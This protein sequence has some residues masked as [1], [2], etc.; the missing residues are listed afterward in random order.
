MEINAK[1]INELAKE[2]GFIRDNLE[3]MAR[4]LQMLDVLFASPWK[5][6]LVLKGGT[7]INLF[8]AGLPRLSVDIDLDYC[9]ASKEETVKDKAAIADFVS[10][11]LLPLGYRLSDAGKT[12]YALDSF[13]LQ[14]VNTAGNQ[15]NVKIE[16][17]SSV[18]CEV[19]LS[20]GERMPYKSGDVMTADGTYRFYITDVAGN[21]F[22]TMVKKDT[23]VEFAFINGYN[24]RPVENGGVI[25]Q[26]SARFVT[27]NKDSSKID[28]IVLNGVEYDPSQAIGFGETGKWEFLISDD[29]GNKT[30]FYFYVVTH[31][32]SRFEYVSPYTYKITNVQY[33]AGDG[34]LIS[35]M[36]NVT[37]YA[38]NSKIRKRF[39]S[40]HGIFYG[41]VGA[42]LV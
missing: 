30:Y 6:K 19:S 12:Y 22:T 3:K 42:I 2:T 15:D 11:A 34:V 23:L 8:Y 14:Y 9:G 26:G 21:I 27:V 20:G 38:N 10:G 31:E 5:D 32:I 4:L 17:D 1:R 35:Y 28:L 25:T 33:D 29:I 7:A 37:Q 36:N 13:V 18:K 41:V 24:D 40:R 16:F 39:V